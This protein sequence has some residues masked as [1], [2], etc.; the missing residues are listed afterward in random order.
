MKRIAHPDVPE[1]ICIGAKHLV[2]VSILRHILTTTLRA[3][4]D[5]SLV[6]L[7]IYKNL[8]NATGHSVAD[9]FVVVCPELIIVF[10]SFH[11]FTH[12]LKFFLLLVALAL[13]GELVVVF[14]TLG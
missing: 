8:L 11:D 1:L 9:C 3:M 2:G 5:F 10:S 13:F 7:V 14:L 12:A 6:V 4:T